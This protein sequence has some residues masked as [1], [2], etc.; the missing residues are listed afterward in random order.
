MKKNLVWIT[1]FIDLLSVAALC[2]WIILRPVEVRAVMSMDGETA[3]KFKGA[4]SSSGPIV[5]ADAQ[6]KVAPPPAPAVEENPGPPPSRPAGPPP[7]RNTR[8]REELSRKTPV[9]AKYTGHWTGVIPDEPPAPEL[10]PFR[11]DRRRFPDD[12]SIQV[13]LSVQNASGYY[14]QD[15]TIVMKSPGFPRAVGFEVGKWRIDQVARLTYEFP[16]SEVGARLELL[17]V[18]AVSGKRIESSLAS[19][20]G[21]RRAEM[22]ELYG[23]GEEIEVGSIDT[24]IETK[25]AVQSRK[26]EIVLPESF[27]GIR[28]NAG[29]RELPDTPDAARAIELLSEASGAADA[30]VETIQDLVGKINETGYEETMTQGGQTLIDQAIES[31]AA[32][33]KSGIDLALLFSRTE[34]ES[35]RN[36]APALNSMSDDLFLLIDAVERQIR[37]KDPEFSLESR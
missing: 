18:V 17:R 26:F 3:G 36:L 9:E 2:A 20:M 35:V 11:V 25:D 10:Y 13:E 23:S 19:H 1:L 8:E 37:V 24:S 22:A 29:L 7:P 27:D 15:A 16:R 30:A 31:K 5:V 32:F 12:T 28:M 4:L 21:Q 14:W 34:D 33:E 6:E